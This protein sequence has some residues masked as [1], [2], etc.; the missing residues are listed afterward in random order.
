MTW[1]SGPHP[2]SA[3]YQVKLPT[4]LV[5]E[6]RLQAGDEFFWRRS[7]DDPAVLILIPAEVVERRYSAGE[8]AEAVNRPRAAELDPPLSEVT[9][10]D[11]G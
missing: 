11:A 10:P 4:K 8:R 5:R 3:Q 7:D 9:P 2:I 1:L 6:L